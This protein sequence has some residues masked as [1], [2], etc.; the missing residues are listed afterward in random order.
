MGCFV[1]HKLWGQHALPVT[2]NRTN[3]I[4]LKTVEAPFMTNRIGI[5]EFFVFFFLYL[6][7]FRQEIHSEIKILLMSNL[8]DLKRLKFNS[9]RNDV[10]FTCTEYEFKKI[11]HF[12]A[13]IILSRAMIKTI[14]ILTEKSIHD[15]NNVMF[16]CNRICIYFLF[17]ILSQ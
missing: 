10:D 3:E 13:S 7:E 2:T 17:T 15:C 11:I 5:S 16:S 4:Q 1:T 6:I 9:T 12:I 14:S 8:I